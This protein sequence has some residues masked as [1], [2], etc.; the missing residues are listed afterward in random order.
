LCPPECFRLS[1]PPLLTPA[2]IS[3]QSD[4]AAFVF[5]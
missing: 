4:H 5:S 2:E 3:V 1:T